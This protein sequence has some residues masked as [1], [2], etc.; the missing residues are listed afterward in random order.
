M[1][2][3]GMQES[4]PE[5][6]ERGGLRVEADLRNRKIGFK[7]RAHSM[8]RVSCLIVVGDKEI[9]SGT[10]SLHARKGEDPGS[11]PLPDMRGKLNLEAASR[12][13]AQ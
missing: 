12:A 8:Q 6:L 3:P 4:L 9:A 11:F 13:V 2:G 10:V 7:I 1:P 5:E